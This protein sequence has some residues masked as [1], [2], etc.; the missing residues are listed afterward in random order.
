MMKD[1]D[2]VYK[3]KDKGKIRAGAGLRLWARFRKE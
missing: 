1:E 3:I 2:K